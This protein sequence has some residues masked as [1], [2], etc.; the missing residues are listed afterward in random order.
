MLL[1]APE[2][3]SIVLCEGSAG[4]E[5][6]PVDTINGLTLDKLYCAVRASP[7]AR[8]TMLC[9]VCVAHALACRRLALH[10]HRTTR[11]VAVRRSRS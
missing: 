10:L 1:L 4:S 3:F 7:E 11:R 2:L 5:L 9:V 6:S 8:A